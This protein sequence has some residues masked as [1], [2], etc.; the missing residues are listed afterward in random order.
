MPNLKLLNFT[1]LGS[2]DS[3]TKSYFVFASDENKYGILEETLFL[4]F[5]SALYMAIILLFDYKV[6]ARL[7]QLFLNKIIGTD[8][9]YTDE[10]IDPNVKDE[11]NRVNLAKNNIFSC[12]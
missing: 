5:S 2:I 3:N 4:F 11:K 12:K 1:F 10:S 6:F 8:I 7:Y 9:G